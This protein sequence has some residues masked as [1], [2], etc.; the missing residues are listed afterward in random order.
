MLPYDVA[1]CD[2]HGVGPQGYQLRADCF[3]CRRRTAFRE[4][5]R[6]VWM[7]PVAEFPC[8]QRLAPVKEEKRD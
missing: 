2:G 4:F 6:V 5:D 7:E 8:P 3:N 1:R